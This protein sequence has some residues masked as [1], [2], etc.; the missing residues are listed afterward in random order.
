MIFWTSQIVGNGNVEFLRQYRFRNLSDR[1]LINE[2]RDRGF[3]FHYH[4]IAQKPY[5]VCR[6]P[7]KW[8]GFVRE[9]CL[10]DLVLRGRVVPPSEVSNQ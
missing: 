2:G 7:V 1:F 4:A 8:K 10:T 6:D 3:S 9:Q 5:N